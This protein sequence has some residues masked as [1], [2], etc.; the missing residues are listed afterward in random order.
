MES[1]DQGRRRSKTRT[2]CITCKNRRVRCDEERPNCQRCIKAGRSCEGYRLIVVDGTFSVLS[3]KNHPLHVNSSDTLLS[4]FR[5]TEQEWQ[6]YGV[7]IQNAASLNAGA[8]NADIWKKL[9]IQMAHTDATVRNAVF[10]LGN[11]FR[12]SKDADSPHISACSCTNCLQAIRSY[13]KSISSFSKHRAQDGPTS[14]NVALASCALF[15]VFEVYRMHDSNGIALIN[16]GSNLLLEYLRKASDTEQRSIDPTILNLFQRLRV[17]SAMFGFPLSEPRIDQDVHAEYLHGQIFDRL[18][19]ARDTLHQIMAAARALRMCAFRALVEM[20]PSD[21]SAT[22]LDLLR[23]DRDQIM[24]RLEAWRKAFE[25]IKESIG[26]QPW[27]S[28]LPT[29]VL[30]AHFSITKVYTETSLDLS[31]SCYDAYYETFEEIVHVAENGIPEWLAESQTV[32][33]SFEACFLAPLY[34][35][36]LKCR[37]GILRRIML[38]LMHFTKAKE[39]LWHRAESIRVA[40]R[41]MELEDGL[42]EFISADNSFRSSGAFIRFHDVMAELNYRTEGKTMVDVVYVLHRPSQECPWLYMKETLVVDE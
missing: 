14:V 9:I 35:A 39:G 6:A 10:A 33:F 26:A 42:S 29:S 4:A 37:E 15:I 1:Q 7:Y 13:N 40:T 17:S 32:S 36:A 20:L 8:F 25:E 18:E 12:H 23:H 28:C 11:L 22:S 3:R 16:K 30:W 38:H 24:L 19:T 5:A 2:A 27:S 41:V 31:Q 21:A 34:L